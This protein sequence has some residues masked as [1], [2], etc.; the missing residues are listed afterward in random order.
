VDSRPTVDNP[1]TNT[2]AKRRS[3]EWMISYDLRKRWLSMKG[4]SGSRVATKYQLLPWDE[5]RVLAPIN[6]IVFTRDHCVPECGRRLPKR[7]T[8]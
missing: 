5:V 4:T 1:H 7:T 2:V 8:N 6:N 3:S